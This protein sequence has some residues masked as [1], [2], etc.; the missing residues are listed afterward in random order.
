MPYGNVG[1]WGWRCCKR[2]NDFLT[3]HRLGDSQF[4][5]W[6][7]F[8]FLVFV[9]V[10]VLF[11]EEGSLA[12]GAPTFVNMGVGWVRMASYAQWAFLLL[13]LLLLM[14]FLFMSSFSLH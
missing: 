4:I 3:G 8:C 1:G 6:A 14:L 7:G 13:L 12:L 9:F 11:F 5:N 10:F 2:C